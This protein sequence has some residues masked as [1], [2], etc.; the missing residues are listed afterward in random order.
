MINSGGYKNIIIVATEAYSEI[1]DYKNRDCVY[2]GDGA[3]AVV[4]SH[5]EGTIYTN[6]LVTYADYP[7]IT[8]IDNDGDLD[9]L[10]FW[11][12]GAFVEMHKNLSMEKY[13]VPDSLDYEKTENCWGHFAENEESNEITLDT[14]F[15]AKEKFIPN[16]KDRHAGSTFLVIDLDGDNDK[17]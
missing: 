9:I 5:G 3:G 2:F 11:G 8:D 10:T 15:G 7:A 14:C 4:L 12:M 6:I 17:D 1:T 16:N 13:G